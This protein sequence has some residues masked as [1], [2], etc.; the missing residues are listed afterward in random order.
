MSK[1]G[2]GLRNVGS[3][4]GHAQPFV[5]HGN[6][7]DARDLSTTKNEHIIEFPFVSRKITVVNHKSGGFKHIHIAFAPRASV[8][9]TKNHFIPVGPGETVSINVKT[10]KVYISGGNLAGQSTSNITVP[11]SIVA[12]LTN[13]PT[14]SM[15]TLDGPGI[16]E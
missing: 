1:Y 15:Y 11:Y 9:H 8:P 14:A 6:I 5:F 4:M 7:G 3:Y 10:D 2:L 13:I 12:E 16:T